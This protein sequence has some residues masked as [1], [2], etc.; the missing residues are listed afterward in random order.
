MKPYSS[1]IGDVL[2]GMVLVSRKNIGSLGFVEKCQNIYKNM[3]LGLLLATALIIFTRSGLSSCLLLWSPA[4]LSGQLVWKQA[5]NKTTRGRNRSKPFQLLPH[6]P[7]FISFII[8]YAICNCVIYFLIYLFFNRKVSF[9]NK[10]SWLLPSRFSTQCCVC[11]KWAM[12]V[13]INHKCI[14]GPHKEVDAAFE[15]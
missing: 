11:S 6:I 8:F 1:N 15:S 10:L 2:L 5:E 4:W 9:M 13:S 12:N 3:K 7:F 14:T